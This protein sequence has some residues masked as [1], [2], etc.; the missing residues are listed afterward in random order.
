MFRIRWQSGLYTNAAARKLAIW[1]APGFWI[2]QTISPSFRIGQPIADYGAWYT[3][4]DW[5]MPTGS[6]A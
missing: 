3:A 2:E 6:D 1:P 4:W 5:G